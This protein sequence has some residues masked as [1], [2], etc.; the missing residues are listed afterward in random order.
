MNSG[1]CARVAVVRVP[2]S[3]HTSLIAD[4]AR[5]RFQAAL[6]N[7]YKSNHVIWA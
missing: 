2:V 1:V 4:A 6:Q 5:S 7:R 3:P